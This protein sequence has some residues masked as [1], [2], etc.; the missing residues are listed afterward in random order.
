MVDKNGILG[1]RMDIF[2]YITDRT[3]N[4]ELIIS[5]AE[6]HSVV[7]E[8]DF[9]KRVESSQSQGI[10]LRTIQEG[11]IGFSFSN[12]F[13]DR[14]IV[15][16]ALESAL[17]GE[18]ACF[19]FSESKNV[20]E[21]PLYHPEVMDTP[22]ESMIGFGERAIE[23]IKDYNPE[24][25]VDVGI[26]KETYQITLKTSNGFDHSYRKSFYSVGVNGLLAKNDQLLSIS[27]GKTRYQAFEDI[28]FLTEPIIEQFKLSTKSANIKTG[29]YKILFTPRAFRSLLSILTPSL[30]GKAVQ[31][32]ISPLDHRLGELIVSKD[33]TLT[34]NGI[35]EDGLATAP[36]DGEGTLTQKNHLFTNGVL[37]TFIYDLQTAGLMKEKSTGSGSRGYS[38]LPSPS[39]RNLRVEPGNESYESLLSGMD[40]GILVDQF[41]G[42]GQSNVMAGEY[43]MNL[44]L[45]FK[46]E[47]GDIV[48]R[49]KDVMM[50]GN[51]FESL[52]HVIALGDRVYREGSGDFPYVLLDQ[53]SVSAKD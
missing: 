17:F 1:D 39:L 31:K 15:D 6:G 21:L 33:F 25:K 4:T 16:R 22:I 20:P 27:K 28:A 34:D 9:F 41:I 44:A 35:L 32:G 45:A 46:V 38:S 2:D 53:I 18:E 19:R 40:E 51:V 42:A 23:A 12:D 7:F 29:S 5:E 13:D 52:N 11:K 24:I 50:S 26:E 36:F 47:K 14:H 8:S 48:G 10:G 43:S 30:N 3:E 49:L 37:N